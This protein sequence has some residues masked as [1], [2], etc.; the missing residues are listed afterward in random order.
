[1]TEDTMQGATNPVGEPVESGTEPAMEMPETPGAAPDVAVEDNAP[2]GSQTAEVGPVAVDEAPAGDATPPE[3]EAVAT[4]EVAHATE[5]TDEFER[6]FAAQNSEA[7]EGSF[8]TF[9]EGDVVQGVV[10]RIDREGVL[11]DVGAKSEGIIRPNELS[12]EAYVS[13]ESIVSVGE[14]IAVYVMQADNDEGNLILSKKRADFEKA[15]ERVL[16]AKDNGKTITAMVTDRVK[17]GL[18]VDLGIRGFVP[19]SHV[20]NGS[21]KTN[22][23]RFVGQSIPLKVLEVDRERHKVILSNKL[24][25][26]EERESRRKATVEALKPGQIRPGI[27]RRLTN[28]GAFVDLGGIDGLLHVSEMSWTRVNHP[29]E[30]LKEGQEIEVLILKMDLTAGRIS[31][32]L[33][34]IL[35]DPW[36]EIQHRY[37]VGQLIQGT[38]TRFVPF[39]VFVQVEGGVE[40]IIHNSELS[41]RRGVKAGDLVKTGETV[42]VKILDLRP[43][44]RKMTLSLRQARQEEE[45][46]HERHVVEEY[47]N[48]PEREESRYTIADALRDR[49]DNDEADED[50]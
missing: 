14:R 45:V 11:V 2:V 1:M 49:E 42:E 32:G 33:R 6:G 39:G 12:R 10:V 31:L 24:A 35:P 46:R 50:G 15:W 25:S 48:R 27:V 19:A 16:E 5:S 4:A 44:E 13:A 9:R 7:Y 17:G 28:Y 43:E 38:I 41:S 36:T 47:H 22:L 20:G 37:T 8:P 18:V 26:E 23:D 40:G 3:A 29:S 21:L 30:V 34:Q